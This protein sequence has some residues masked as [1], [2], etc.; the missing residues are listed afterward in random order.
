MCIHGTGN[1]IW[2]TT[3]GPIPSQAYN[4]NEPA[5]G[6]QATRA[7]WLSSLAYILGGNYAGQELNDSW[8][9]VLLHQFHDIIPG[10]SIHE[11]Y[12][13]S[14]INYRAAQVRA[15]Q[16]LS[17]ALETVVREEEHVFSVYS[18]NSFRGKELVWIEEPGTDILWT[19][20][21]RRWRRRE[22]AVDMRC[23]WRYGPLRRLP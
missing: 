17:E 13:D 20:E 22:P 6:K 15:D 21:D 16:V 9:C 14:R 12:E 18:T 8:E 2:N 7:E 3:E 5:H 23:W 11:V 1:C 4:K 10:S 19:T